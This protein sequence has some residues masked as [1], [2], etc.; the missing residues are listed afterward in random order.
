MHPAPRYRR[1][2][3]KKIGAFFA[4]HATGIGHLTLCVDSFPDNQI[5]KT[6]YSYTVLRIAESILQ[7]KNVVLKKILTYLDR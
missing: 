2:L 5:L 7:K 6:R 4:A 3:V 1:H